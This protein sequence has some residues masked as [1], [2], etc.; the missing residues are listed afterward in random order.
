MVRSVLKNEAENLANASRKTQH[1]LS[2]SPREYLTKRDRQVEV[3]FSMRDR[4]RT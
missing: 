2:R 4:Q 3:E 1:E